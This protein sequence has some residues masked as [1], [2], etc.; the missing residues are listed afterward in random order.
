MADER[1]DGGVCLGESS[2]DLV[3][4]GFGDS[5]RVCLEGGGGDDSDRSLGTGDDL[6]EVVGGH[7]GAD[8]VVTGLD[9]GSVLQ[10]DL[11][12][13]DGVLGGS[14]LVGSVSGGVGAHPLADGD[15]GGVIGLCSH[16][17]ALGGRCVDKCLEVRSGLRLDGVV[18]GNDL[19]LLHRLGES[20]GDGG[21]SAD[22]CGDFGFLRDFGYG[23]DLLGAAYSNGDSSL[24]CLHVG[25][26]HGCHEGF[27]GFRGKFAVLFVAIH[28]NR[29]PCHP[30]VTGLCVR[31]FCIPY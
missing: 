15:P 21:V 16:D 24:G 10:D 14:V 13:E 30:G 29:P 6:V 9:D 31:V 8:V 26:T 3:C 19:D 1:L 20:D 18:L 7:V 28:F 25:G 22:C 4:E 5:G 2:C 23:S 11:K 17:E 27:A 12:V